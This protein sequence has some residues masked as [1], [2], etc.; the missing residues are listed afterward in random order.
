MNILAKIT[1]IL[2]PI[3]PNKASHGVKQS[4]AMKTPC[5]FPVTVYKFPIGMTCND[6]NLKKKYQHTKNP[7]IYP[8]TITKRDFHHKQNTIFHKVLKKIWHI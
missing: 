2:A 6:Q 1:L 7:K 3:K 5:P 8:F 4:K